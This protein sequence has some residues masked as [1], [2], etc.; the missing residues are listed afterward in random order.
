MKL[1]M[2]FLSHSKEKSRWYPNYTISV[3]LQIFSTVIT[4]FD[5]IRPK[6]LTEL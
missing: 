2:D 5:V 1:I 6:A 3:S 4:S